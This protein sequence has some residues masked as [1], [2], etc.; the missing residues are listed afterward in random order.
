[1]AGLP[2]RLSRLLLAV[3]LSGDL[4][5]S[6]LAEM[7]GDLAVDDA[8]DAGLLVVEGDRVRPSHPLLAAAARSRARAREQRAMHLELA[9]VLAD[10]ELHALHLALAADG[11]DRSSPRP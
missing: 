10:S 4:R 7:C 9:R 3:A 1:M 8:V 11:P 6:Q 2:R 5:V